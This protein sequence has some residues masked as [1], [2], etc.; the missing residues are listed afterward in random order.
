MHTF[1][2]AKLFSIFLESSETHFDLVASKIGAKLNNL[3]IYGDILV[4]FNDNYVSDFFNYEDRIP[5]LIKRSNI[6]YDYE[7]SC[8]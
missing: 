5:D 2:L 1:F 7:Y 8:P 6:V 3:V 4:N